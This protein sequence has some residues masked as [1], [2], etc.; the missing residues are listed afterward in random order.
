M[1][2]QEID[3]ISVAVGF[4]IVRGMNRK[5]TNFEYICM[6]LSKQGIFIPLLKDSICK[7]VFLYDLD[8]DNLKI[9]YDTDDNFYLSTKDIRNNAASSESVVC[10]PT[11]SN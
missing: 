6:P 4:S 1:K 2:E 8:F 3:K 11:S 9:H 7:T 5:Q 10:E